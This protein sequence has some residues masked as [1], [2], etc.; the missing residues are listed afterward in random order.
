MDVLY[1]VCC[2]VRSPV[3][4]GMIL[5]KKLTFQENG[6]LKISQTGQ[7]QGNSDV[8]KPYSV[9]PISHLYLGHIFNRLLPK[10]F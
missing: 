3:G 1:R 4:I 6:C 2:I 5:E 8:C 7:P 10:S 9:R